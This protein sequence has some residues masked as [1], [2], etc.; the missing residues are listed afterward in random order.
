MTLNFN[1]KIELNANE[2]TKAIFDS[3]ATDNKF[4]PQNPKLLFLMAQSNEKLGYPIKAIKQY[5]KILKITPDWLDVYDSLAKVYLR[6]GMFRNAINVY[7]Q[8]T[9]YIVQ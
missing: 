8:I 3:I 1:A 9:W 2:K 6:S 5:K 4:Y 7:G